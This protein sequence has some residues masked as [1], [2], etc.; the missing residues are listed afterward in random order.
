VDVTYDAFKPYW[1]DGMTPIL[2]MSLVTNV[3]YG[4]K[5]LTVN[6][7]VAYSLLHFRTVALQ[8]LGGLGIV[9]KRK[10]KLQIR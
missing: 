4:G 8:A 3:Y 5:L 7:T 9:R 1:R 2:T 10:L 6:G